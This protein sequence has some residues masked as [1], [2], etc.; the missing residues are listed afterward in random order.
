MGLALSL[1]R[2]PPALAVM[3]LGLADAA[4]NFFAHANAAL[5][6]W[7]ETLLRRLVITPDMHRIHHSEDI[8]DR[9]RNFG[10]VFPWWD[11]LFGTYLPE[12][13][14]GQAGM[15][16]GLKDGP[17]TGLIAMLADPF[18]AEPRR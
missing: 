12:P 14:A 7:M 9:N 17:E 5:P 16:V 13:A 15:A 8:A 6:G 18:L 2:F 4:V 11:R 1:V 10:I 3:A